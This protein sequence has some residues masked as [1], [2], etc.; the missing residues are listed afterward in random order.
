MMIAENAHWL[1]T[2]YQQRSNILI[3]DCRTLNE[4]SKGHIEGSINLFIPPL[5]LRRLKKGNVP[6]K[7][8]INSEVA[9]E[10]FENRRLCEKVVLYDEDSSS[11]T[12]DCILEILAKKLCDDNSIIYLNG[13]NS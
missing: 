10:K 4:Y 8:F 5:M 2:Q 7:N 1:F 9:K 13:K 11:I 6:L 3:I 12:D